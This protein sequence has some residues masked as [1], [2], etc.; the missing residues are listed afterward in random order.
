[1]EREA[2]IVLNLL[3]TDAG[4]EGENGHSPLLVVE[5]EDRELG[6]D[7]KHSSGD[8]A[9]LGAGATSAQETWAGD[10]IDLL[11]EAPLL[12]LHRDDHAGQARNVVS[13]AGSRQAGFRR[14]GIADER[15]VQVAVLI[16]LRASHEADIHIAALEQ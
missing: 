12:V 9:A 2:G 7:A 16:D 3:A 8:E 13:A 14:R 11:D 15:R 6:D 5:A 10:E 1:V 4:I